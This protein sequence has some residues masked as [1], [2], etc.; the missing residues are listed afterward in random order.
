MRNSADFKYHTVSDYLD[1]SE[2]QA[3]LQKI[4]DNIFSGF[5]WECMTKLRC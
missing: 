2:Q 4:L 1:F 5:F 3:E